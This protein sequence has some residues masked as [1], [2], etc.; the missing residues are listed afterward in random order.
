MQVRWSLP[1]IAD[2]ERI[3]RYI[4]RDNPI[5]AREVVDRLYSGCGALAQFPRRGRA[6]RMKGRRELVFDGLPYIAV[7]RVRRDAVEI[8]RIY[9]DAQDWP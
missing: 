8:S 3:A 4:R 2:L 7:Y 5:A 1:A 6:G 9:H